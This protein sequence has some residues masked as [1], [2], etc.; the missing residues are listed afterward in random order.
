MAEDDVPG[1]GFTADTGATLV[2]A[3]EPVREVLHLRE[4]RVGLFRD[5]RL[6]DIIDAPMRAGAAALLGEGRHRVDVVALG[7]VAGLRV[8]AA[9]WLAALDRSPALALAEA[10]RQAAARAALEDGFA[11]S[12]GDLDDFF[13]PGGRLVPGPYTFG[14]VALTAFVMAGERAALR[15]LL[16]PG[17]RLIPGLGGASLLVLAEVG[18][19]RTDGPGGPTRA[20][21]Y[22]ELAV[23]IPCVGPRGRLGVF[24]PAL[25]VTAT[26]AILLGREIYGFPKRPGRIWLHSDGAE[27]ALDHRLALRLGWGEGTP[28]AAG[29]APRALR[30]LLRPRVFTRKVIAGV[31]GRDRVDELVES[32]FS[33]LD[34]GRLTRLAEPRVEHLDPWLPPLGR[35]TA[36][37]SLQAAYRL[38]RGRVLRRNP[39][40]RR[41]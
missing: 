17:L 4:G 40:R 19:S 2:R 25:V 34:L 3:G 9:S 7:P 22:R 14:P 36:A 41:R 5:G 24:V 37:F 28:L 18:G 38:G 10:R 6:I 15:A 26:M 29:A 13:A 27:V 23:F 35:P 8:P 21:A 31:A 39:R 11:A 16:P 12:L 30:A 33:L 20:G 1:E 32:R